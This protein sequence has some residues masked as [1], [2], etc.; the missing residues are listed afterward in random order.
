MARQSLSQPLIPSIFDRLIDINPGDTSDGEGSQQKN[1]KSLRESVR[2]D[3][4][5][6]L[7][8]RI[9]CFDATESSAE[10]AFSAL[11]YGIPDFY[12]MKLISDREKERF[13]KKLE[14]LISFYEPRFKTVHV[15]LVD[16]ADELDRTLRFRIDAMLNVQPAAKPIVFDSD[17]E[18]VTHNFRVRD[19]ESD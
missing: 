18:L 3:L 4:E 15:E 17:M 19:L 13:R 8:T 9:P 12:G 1:I 10:D 11:K 16:G 2:R 7:N 5:S 14:Q 6:L